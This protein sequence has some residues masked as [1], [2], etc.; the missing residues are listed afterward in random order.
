MKETIDNKKSNRK[1]KTF[2][3][4]SYAKSGFYIGI[5]E[6]CGSGRCNFPSTFVMNEDRKRCP[7]HVK[8][9][10]HVE[11]QYQDPIEYKKYIRTYN[12]HEKHIVCKHL[13]VAYTKIIT[14][15][16]NGFFYKECKNLRK[17]VKANMSQRQRRD[18]FI[19][20]EA[21]SEDSMF[22]N[23]SVANFCKKKLKKYECFQLRGR[24]KEASRITEKLMTKLDKVDKLVTSVERYPPLLDSGGVDEV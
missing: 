10:S 9:I 14:R 7:H 20:K 11:A 23:R 6:P 15:D 24:Y 8:E 17:L 13:G 2:F 22:N 1:T 19:S 5:Y 12:S 16:A 3:R 18:R 4:F 21:K